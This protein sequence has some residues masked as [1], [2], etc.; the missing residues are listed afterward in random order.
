MVINSRTNDFSQF[1]R[2]DIK[3]HNDESMETVESCV[4]SRQRELLMLQ[5]NDEMMKTIYLFFKFL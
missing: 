1:Y 2:P 5:L 4:S 3:Q